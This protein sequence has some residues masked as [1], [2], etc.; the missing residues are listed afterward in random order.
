MK[1]LLI[2]DEEWNDFVYGNGVLTNWFTGFN[3][4]FAQVYCSPGKPINSICSR[5]FQITD[6]QMVQ[7]I[8]GLAKAGG[9]IL[10]DKSPELINESKVNAQRKGIYAVMKRMALYMP[11]PILMIRDLIWQIGRYDK[12]ALEKFVTDFNPDVVFCPRLITPKLMRLERLVSQYTSAPFVAFTAD[13]EASLSG[14]SFSPLYWI[15]KF[16]IHKMFRK[17]VALYSKYLMFSEDQVKEYTSK[18]GVSAETLYKCGDFSSSF[19]IKYVNNPIHIVYAGRLYCNRWKT[20]HEVGKALKVINCE[21][22]KMV[23]EVYT[24]EKLTN[25]QKKAL[26]E[27]YYVYVKGRVTPSELEVIYQNADIALHVESMDKKNRLLTRVSFSTKIIDLM[28]S[29]CAI[30]AICWDKHTGYQYLSKRDAAFCLS[31][32]EEIL[33]LLQRISSNPSLIN[34]YS[35][36]AFECGKKYHSRDVIQNQIYNIFKNMMIG[37]S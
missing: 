33:P 1:I 2:T 16:Y 28:A 25:E 4:E 29:T 14:V 23:L 17:H 21:N 20:L 7:S 9:N 18:Y 36:K 12:T 26:S 31:T 13:D 27:E 30:I 15:R 10:I 11:S 19:N 3:A 34:T 24:T 37:K 8:F 32:Y 5:Y 22:V 6:I 35:R